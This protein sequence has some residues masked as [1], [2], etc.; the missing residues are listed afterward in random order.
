MRQRAIR[1]L[2]RLNT[3][4]ARITRMLDAAAGGKNN[5]VADRDAVRRYDEAAPVTTAAAR[6]VLAFLS[7]VIRHLAAGG[8]D[9]FVIVG[10]GVPSG[11]PAGRQLHDLAREA[12]GRSDVRVLY[13]ENDPMVLAYAQATIEPVTD[14]VRVV[15]GDIRQV[16]DLLGDRVVRTFVDWDRPVGLVLVSV[17]SLGDEEA[18][19]AIKCLCHAAARGSYLA[20][21]QT[22]FDAIPDE[23]L[24]AIGELLA[25]T[26]PGHVVRTRAEAAA[27]LEGLDLVDPGLVWV[28]E[29]R[30]DGRDE[31]CAAL[32]SA[33]GNYGA[34]ARVL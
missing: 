24:P 4:Q 8:I 10:S 26:L 9:Q 18:R 32:P 13:V 2:A 17:P 27:L 21:L 19:H 15:E 5:F 34:V 28:P 14:L 22:T 7:R 12:L 20:L 25:M 3:S 29:W 23:L 16:E 31:A 30:P 33:S 11:L 6:A 1:N